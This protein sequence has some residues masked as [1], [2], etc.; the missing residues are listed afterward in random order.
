MNTLRGGH[1]SKAYTHTHAH[2]PILK[3][4]QNDTHTYLHTYTY[5][6]TENT[7]EVFSPP[8]KPENLTGAATEHSKLTPKHFTTSQEHRAHNC[9]TLG[10]AGKKRKKKIVKHECISVH[11]FPCAK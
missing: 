11:F 6:H 3:H 9:Y 4:L 8:K 5:R 7:L 10:V 2:I 1:G